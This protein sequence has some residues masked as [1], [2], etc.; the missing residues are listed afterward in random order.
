MLQFVKLVEI[1]KNN[2]GKRSLGIPTQSDRIAHMAVV[3]SIIPTL[4]TALYGC[5][6]NKSAHDTVAKARERCFNGY[7]HVL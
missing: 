7:N 3:L 6:S 4:D 1:L 2:G 5:R